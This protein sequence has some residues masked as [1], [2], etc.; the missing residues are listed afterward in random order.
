M[1]MSPTDPNPPQRGPRAGDSI[2]IQHC[3]QF[4]GQ[5][6][7][8][9]PDAARGISI[10]S[11]TPHPTPGYPHCDPRRPLLLVS[12]PPHALVSPHPLGFSAPFISPPPHLPPP[13]T[14]PV[15]LTG[16]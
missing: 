2:S 15:R 12:I 9:C 1:L 3:G 4:H 6:L 10:Q 5:H 14:Q 11:P 13:I 7:E 8:Q 16:P